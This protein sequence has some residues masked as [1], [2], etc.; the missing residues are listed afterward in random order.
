MRLAWLELFNNAILINKSVHTDNIKFIHP[1]IFSIQENFCVH[2]LV[3]FGY[4]LRIWPRI[5][6]WRPMSKGDC[7]TVDEYGPSGAWDYSVG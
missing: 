6:F 2:F 5:S 7:F 3:V 1:I 4:S